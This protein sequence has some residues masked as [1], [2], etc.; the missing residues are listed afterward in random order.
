MKPRRKTL[1]HRARWRALLA[2]VALLAPLGASAPAGATIYARL[3]AEAMALPA[4]AG[5]VFA[6]PAASGG[7]ALLVW[8]NA[9]ASG[10]VATGSAN[11]VTVRARADLCEGAPRMQLAVD[12]AVVLTTTVAA[13]TW[14]AYTAVVALSPGTHTLAVGFTNDHRTAACDRNLR[15][16]RVGVWTA[17]PTPTTPT[18]TTPTPT[19][20][21]ASDPLEGRKLYVDPSSDAKRQADAWRAARPADAARMDEI[22]NRPQA[23]WFGDWDADVGAA[24]ARRVATVRAAGALP[25]L[26]AYDIPQRDCGSYSAGGAGSPDAYRAWVRAFA[27]GLGAG[28]A[29]VVLEPDALAGMDCLSEADR[30][31]RLGL[32]KDAVAVLEARPG[33]SVY[34]DAGHSGWHG[35][36]EMASRLTAAGV[37]Q[38]RG[39]SL[40]VSAYGHTADQV[41]YAKD[42]SARLGGKSAVVDTSRNGLGPAPDAA[43]CNPP[44]RALGSAP[45]TATA[46]AVV[47]AYLWVKQP[48]ESDGTCNGGPPAGVFWPDYALGL[49]QRA[50]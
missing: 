43:W 12:G 17:T 36:A 32:L 5:Q 29:V 1:A 31:V 4:E 45:T 50:A 15:V 11:R 24:V 9:T 23:D 41:A 27:S 37:A 28:E 40:N 7:Q 14:S 3:E 20:P 42:L 35:A 46:D 33:V 21:A 8:S 18:P 47:D 38:A 34:L 2:G 48:G 10:P 39:F 26:V 49:A 22:A 13:T 16:D 25:V 6:D 44:G 30:H 19:T